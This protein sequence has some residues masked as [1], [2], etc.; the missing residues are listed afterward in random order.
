MPKASA[1]YCLCYFVRVDHLKMSLIKSKLIRS[2]E[3]TK[4]WNVVL[5]HAQKLKLQ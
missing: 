3:D 1:V 2:F 4:V 5:G